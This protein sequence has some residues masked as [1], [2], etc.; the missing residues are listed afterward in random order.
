MREIVK[1]KIQPTKYIKAGKAIR[2]DYILV[3]GDEAGWKDQ[4]HLTWENMKE[5]ANYVKVLENNTDHL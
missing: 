5:I 3:V 1:I 4:V 2:E